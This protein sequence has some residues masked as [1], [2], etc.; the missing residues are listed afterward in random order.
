MPICSLQDV[1]RSGFDSYAQ[2][3]TLH[4]RESNAARSI[5]GCYTSAMGAH[6]D[7]CPS[8]DYQHLQFHA[9]RHRSCPRCAEAARSRWIDAQMQRL[10]PCAHFHTVFTV[11]HSFLALWERNRAWFIGALFDCVRA[12]LLQ[13]LA[14][15]RHLGAT[16]GLLMSLH[17]WGRNLSHHPHLHCLVSAGGLDEQGLWRAAR[18]GWLLPLKPLQKLY[19]GKLLDALWRALSAGQLVLPPWSSAESWKQHI[20]RLYRKSFNIEICPPYEHGRGVV[21]YLARYAKGGP[22]PAGRALRLH[23]GQVSLRYTDHHDGQPK[24]LRLQQSEFIAR[25]LWHAPPRG[26]HTTRH[27]GL[28]SSARRAQH[29]RAAELLAAT[30]TPWPRTK[31]AAPAPAQPQR[32]PRCS[33]PLLRLAYFRPS[34]RRRSSPAP[35]HGISL[36]TQALPTGPPFPAP[37]TPASARRCPTRRSS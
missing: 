16:P 28:Y 29:A 34:M 21:L 25:V 7:V 14:D 5:G 11:P 10:L 13:L 17:T 26:V 15:P 18:S 23:Q 37:S 12:S 8:G 3:R 20:K 22:L 33:G 30:P 32:C 9:C 6:L 2:G 27:A 4:P 19:R 1:F 31:P 36:S 35:A 24:T